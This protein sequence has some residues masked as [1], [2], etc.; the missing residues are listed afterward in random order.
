MRRDRTGRGSPADPRVHRVR[1]RRSGAVFGA[2]ASGGV[3]LAVVVS[4]PTDVLR[5]FVGRL[6]AHEPVIAVPDA[7]DGDSVTTIR[8]LAPDEVTAPRGEAP[9]GTGRWGHRQDG[10]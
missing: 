3:A 2:L 1:P 5:P 7:D 4:A 9:V 8:E 6:R 10:R